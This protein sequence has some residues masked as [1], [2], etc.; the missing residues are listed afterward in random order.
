MSETITKKRDI[1]ER[2]IIYFKK[3]KGQDK[4][5]PGRSSNL[6]DTVIMLLGTFLGISLLSILAFIY[7]MPLLAAPFGAS[8]V[9]VYGAPNNNFSQPRN[10]I[11]GH[12]YSAI[13]GVVVFKLFG[14]CWWSTTIGISVALLVMLVTKTTHP[15]GGATALLAILGGAGPMYILTPILLGSV[16]IVL[17][18]VLVN[19]IS[20]RCCYPRY[21]F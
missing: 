15:P 5:I 8:A 16:A 3:F 19:N 13:I 18:G 2:L 7:K 4:R 9:L 17:I 1:R 12:T 20:P 21:W 11:L 6:V 10:V 14:L